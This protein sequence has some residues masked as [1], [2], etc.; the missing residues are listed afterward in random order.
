MTIMTTSQRLRMRGRA[1][2]VLSTG[3]GSLGRSVPCGSSPLIRSARAGGFYQRA[4]KKGKPVGSPPADA[5]PD[6]IKG[7]GW[8]MIVLRHM[9]VLPRGERSTRKM[10]H[11]QRWPSRPV[12]FLALLVAAST[13]GQAQVWKGRVLKEGE[14]T[15]VQNP[16]DPIH[17]EPVLSLREDWTIGGP[18]STGDPARPALEHRRR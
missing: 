17:K 13:L 8:R 15:I 2:L 12:A 6:L 14:V 4:G 7:R 9:P 18:A 11:P 1:I 16:R 3:R 5:R 10:P